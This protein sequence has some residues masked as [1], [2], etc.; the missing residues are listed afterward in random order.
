MVGLSP[1]P[2]TPNVLSFGEYMVQNKLIDKHIVSLTT[3]NIT[4]GA[5]ENR[6][7]LVW[8]DFSYDSDYKNWVFNTDEM[9]ING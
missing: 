2:D 6:D 9:R 8:N 5:H 3:S 7:D 1:D 4:F